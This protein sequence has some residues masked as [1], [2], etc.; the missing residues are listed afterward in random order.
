LRLLLDL[1]NTSSKDLSPLAAIRQRRLQSP[2]T[3]LHWAAD[4]GHGSCVRILLGCEE[5]RQAADKP[6]TERRC[7]GDFTAA[8]GST[9]LMLAARVGSSDVIRQIVHVC[10]DVL[11]VDRQDE[12][13]L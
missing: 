11:V 13:G 1:S 6:I 7:V 2:L 4:G 9:P 5:W 3:P 12:D 8:A 10:S